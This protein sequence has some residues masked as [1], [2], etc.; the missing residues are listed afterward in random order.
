MKGTCHLTSVV[1]GNF[2]LSFVSS[3][4]NQVYGKVAD[5]NRIEVMRIHPAGNN[6]NMEN[7]DKTVEL[8]NGNYRDLFM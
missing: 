8:I 6:F 5:G 2:C 3:Q 1:F 7:Y 4:Y